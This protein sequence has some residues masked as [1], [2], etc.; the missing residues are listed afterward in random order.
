MLEISAAVPAQSNMTGQQSLR[1][2]I[3]GL[4][5][6]RPFRD[7]QIHI[8]AMLNS[9]VPAAIHEAGEAG[10]RSLPACRNELQEL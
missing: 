10:T 4:A 9:L 6:F 1:A 7:R 3:T 8:D 5:Q 2:S